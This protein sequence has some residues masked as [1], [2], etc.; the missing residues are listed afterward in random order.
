M[1]TF[2]KIRFGKEIK[3]DHDYILENYDLGHSWKRN[4]DTGNWQ[5]VEETVPTAPQVLFLELCVKMLKEGG[6][7]CIVLPE[8]IFGNLTEG[9][10]RQWL[11]NN[12]TILA[13]WD[14]PQTLFLPH[15]N[16]KTC[17]LFLKKEKIGNQCILMSHL[18]KTGHDQRGAEIKIGGG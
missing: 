10:V 11:L 6:T 12:V 17:I 4:K 15:T 2:L 16:T 13:I 18:Q 9:Y 5:K 1:I 8:G 14:C 3:V 7:M